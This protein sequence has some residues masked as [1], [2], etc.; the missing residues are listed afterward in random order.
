MKHITFFI[1][2][3][4][5]LVCFGQ[6]NLK[7]N[8]AILKQL[9]IG[10]KIP[11]ITI[12]RFIN[13]DKKKEKLSNFYK[14]GLLILDFWSTNCSSCV[15]AFPKIT[16]LENEFSDKMNVLLV[17]YQPLNT[18]QKFLQKGKEL[19]GIEMS[20]PIAC[21]DTIL[22]KLFDPPSFPHYVWIDRNGVVKYITYPWSVTKENIAAVLSNQPVQME[23]KD[24]RYVDVNLSAPLFIDGNGGNGSKILRYSVLSGY[25]KNAPSFQGIN[26]IHHDSLSLI[27][28]CN[29]PIKA[30]FQTAFSDVYDRYGQYYIPDNRTLLDVADSTHYVWENNERAILWQNLYC[31]QRIMPKM[32]HEDLK[33]LMQQDLRLYFGLAGRLEK[34][35]V[36]CLVLSA[37]DTAL[38]ASKGGGWWYRVNPEAHT[39][40]IRDISDSTLTFEFTRML[41]D[42]PY[43]FIDELGMKGNMD[44]TLENYTTDNL[45]SIQ[46]ALSKYKM[47]LKIEERKVNMLIITE[48]N[49]ED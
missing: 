30:M 21:E 48:A 43:P 41:S 46:K 19:S 36:K 15:E 22:K 31:Y 24:N 26:D 32:P 1:L 9:K 44:F 35:K 33:K 42:Y 45:E 11:D 23:L 3:F 10:D 18:I 16:K 2:I 27:S 4:C 34:R 39:L 29:Y 28:V 38:I 47:N 5:S 17:A 14:K 6:K 37:E 49:K 25:V 8:H 20:L 12:E 7:D 13:Y 40:V